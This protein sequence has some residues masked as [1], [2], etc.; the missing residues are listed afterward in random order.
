[1][2]STFMRRALALAQRGWGQTAPNPMVGAVVVR[3][4]SIV[5]E[6]FHARFGEPH[7]E[8]MALRMAGERARGATLY[9]SLEPCA[10]HGKTPPCVDA[11]VAAGV[12]R[13]VIAATDANPV[14]AGGA[15]VLRAAGIEVVTGVEEA[16]ARELNAPFFFAQGAARPWITLKLAVSI[17][18]ALTDARRSS[19]WL[20]GPA[21]RAEV[22]RM[23]AGSDA[24]AV[25]VGTLL[26]DDAQ[27]TVRD[28]PP[29]RVPPRRVVF[30]D[31]LETPPDARLLA[32]P[33]VAPVT[34]LATRGEAH[35]PAERR[36]RLE[37]AGAEVIVAPSM[38]VGLEAL[39]A[40]GVR[41]LLVEGGA[42]LAGSLL[43]AAVVDRLVIFQAPIVLGQGALHAFSRAPAA[44]VDAAERLPVVERRVLGDDVMTVYAFTPI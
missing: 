30:D 37:A 31:R 42:G 26:A 27:L 13:V 43:E 18:G 34:V 5:G 4:D 16:A 7:A 33:L 2:N 15:K 6:G 3:D 17:D 1:M 29:P 44:T 23:R 10:H 21:A 19:G 12:S 11:I 40:A 9:V 41:S 35:A 8:P 32:S 25:G 20:T 39:R 22:H 24:I 36:R 14:A 28:S 38:P